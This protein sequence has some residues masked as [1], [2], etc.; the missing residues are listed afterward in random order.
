MKADRIESGDVFDIFDA[1]SRLIKGIRRGHG[2]AFLECLTYRWKEH[3]GPADDFHLGY[4]TLE[5]MKCW[6]RKDALERLARLIPDKRRRTI[7]KKAEEEIAEAFSFSEKSP[8]PGLKEL[9]TEV[10]K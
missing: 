9:Y 4:R 2:P 5:E 1:A 7:E 3:V 10:F 6:K 8:F